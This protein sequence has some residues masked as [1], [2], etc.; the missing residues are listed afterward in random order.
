MADGG[1][2][3]LDELNSMDI[4]LQPK[5][6]KVIE[7]QKFRPIGSE[8]EVEVNVRFIAAMNMNPEDAVSTGLLRQDLYYRLDVIDIHIPPLRERPEDILPII[9]HYIHYY[10]QQMDKNIEGLTSLAKTP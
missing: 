6:L 7:Q 5:L 10:S 2:L 9:D 3:F 8:K 4:S 1:T